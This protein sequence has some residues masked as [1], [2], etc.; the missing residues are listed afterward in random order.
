M[1]GTR[2]VRAVESAA[3][4]WE[5]M[6]GDA[7]RELSDLSDQFKTMT[8]Y[9]PYVVVGIGVVALVALVVALVAVSRE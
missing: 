8:R 5:A 3:N 4:E 2:T 9:G 6:A 1:F 7:R